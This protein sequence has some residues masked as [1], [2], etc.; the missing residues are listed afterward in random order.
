M[1]ALV[2]TISSSYGAG[3]S[4]V[5]PRVA[6]ELGLPYWDRAWAPEA[7]ARAGGEAAREGLS[8]EEHADGVLRR[9]FT[10]AA[11]MPAAV[12]AIAP[13]PT[14]PLS[15]EER[16][17]AANE[18]GILDLVRRGG[19]VIR[20]R[21]AAAFLGRQPGCLHVR[22]DGPEATRLALGMRIEGIDEQEARRRLVATDRTREQYVRRFYSRDVHDPELYD[23]T[24]D[25]GETDLAACTGII[26]EA[27]RTHMN[28]QA[29]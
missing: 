29:T 14:A 11:R 10:A 8:L 5:G 4:I 26:V 12:G 3:G 24:L 23:L 25:T 6:E 20:G 28:R 19:G 16:F 17:R 27:A 2:V 13:P 18:A 15:D 21:G 1:A 7:V 9:L 22:L